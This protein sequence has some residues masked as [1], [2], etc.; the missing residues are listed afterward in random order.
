[1]NKS[2]WELTLIFQRDNLVREVERQVDRTAREASSCFSEA[3]FGNAEDDTRRKET[4][5]DMRTEEPKGQLG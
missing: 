3:V 1:M 5:E 2:F 4:R